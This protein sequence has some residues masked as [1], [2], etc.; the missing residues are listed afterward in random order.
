MP[1]RMVDEA[2]RRPPSLVGRRGSA[3]V[4]P[5]TRFTGQYRFLSNFWPCSPCQILLPDDPKPRCW[6][7]SVEHAYQA[8]KTLSPVDRYLI[9]LT[10][11]PGTAKTI[12]RGLTLRHWTD[13]RRVSIM[14]VLLRQKFRDPTLRYMLL[15]TSDA[16]LVE[17]NNWHDNFFGSCDCIRRCAGLEHHNHLGKLL[18]QIR[19]DIA[20]QQTAKA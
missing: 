11:E 12:G 10:P 5:I 1:V 20:N 18:M 15:R 6:Y 7:R 19:S 13:A 16:H 17:G 8:Y 4:E 14:R 2:E 3:T 9:R